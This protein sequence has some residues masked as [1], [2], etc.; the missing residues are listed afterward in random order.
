MTLEELIADINWIPLRRYCEVLG[1]S[2]STFHMRKRA[3][4]WKEGV[5]ICTPK[6]ADTHVNIRAVAEW[7][8]AHGAP[9][10]V[11]ERIVGALADQV[12]KEASE[13]LAGLGD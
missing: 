4:L 2:R 8:E 7:F 11:Q 10:G 1:V 9:S 6:G 12:R 5:H 3:G 13:R